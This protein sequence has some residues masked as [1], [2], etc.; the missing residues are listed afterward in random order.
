M[1]PCGD[2]ILT[3]KWLARTLIV[4][5]PL[6]GATAAAEES[7]CWVLDPAH[8]NRFAANPTTLAAAWV[9]LLEPLSAAIPSLSPK[10]EQWLREE[11]RGGGRRSV[12]AVSSREYAIQ[13]AKARADAE[14]TLMRRLT[15]ERDR[16][17]QARDWLWFAYSLIDTDAALYLA[18]LEAD[19]VIQRDAIPWNWRAFARG[20]GG[21][22]L[23][24]VIRWG[25]TGLAKHILRCTLPT[26][27]GVSMG[28][29]MVE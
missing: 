14:L 22:T 6:L 8:P 10:E 24:K 13:Q 29:R 26:V 18:R 5:L 25:R 9:P 23:Q 1:A 16:V 21:A 12:R 17:A 27:I 28:S 7:A 19:G 11:M 4:I 3:M 15:E 2:Y 20:K